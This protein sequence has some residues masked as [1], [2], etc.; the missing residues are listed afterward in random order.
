MALISISDK[1]T[2]RDPNKFQ[3]RLLDAKECN[4]QRG[5]QLQISIFNQHTS[6]INEAE[7]IGNT[8]KRDQ[9]KRKKKEVRVKKT[10]IT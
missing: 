6:N 7:V 9:N 5:Y 3:R 1:V 8:R 2:F 10:N 4:P